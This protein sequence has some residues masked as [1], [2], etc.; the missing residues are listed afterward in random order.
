MSAAGC[1]GFDAKE[2]AELL[3]AFRAVDMD[4]SGHIDYTEF[5]AAC[6]D[7]KIED[8]E[9]ACWAAFQVFDLNS[10]GEVS[11]EE[12]RQVVTSASMQDAFS[13][14]TMQQLWQQLTGHEFHAES[15][16]EGRVDFDHF[17]AALR[18]VRGSAAT[19]AE[20]AV[21]QQQGQ[22]A[23]AAP[24]SSGLPIA[25]RH[26]AAVASM[27]LPISSRRGS[28]LG[29]PIASR[30]EKPEAVAAPKAGGLPIASRGGGGLGLPISSRH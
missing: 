23:A 2:P 15:P 9:G 16:C 30:N 27:G 20:P 28:S 24:V 18:G 7:R 4:G 5:I 10:D 17:L 29:L 21:G 11:Y 19:V 1:G 3:A 14:S 22:E 12:L 13:Q 26:H 8:Q 6:I 25:R